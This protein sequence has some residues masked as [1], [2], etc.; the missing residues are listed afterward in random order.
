MQD[1]VNIRGSSGYSRGVGSRVLILIDGLPY[2]TGDTGEIPWKTVPMFQIDRIEVVKG[3]GSALDGS[4]A[5]GGVINVITKEMGETPEIRFR[6]FQGL[7]ARPKYAEWNWSPNARFNSGGFVSYSNR[8]GSFGY[9]VSV[10]RMVDDSYR[11]NDVY[12]RWGLDENSII[13][14]R[15][16]RV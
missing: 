9:L 13:I 1:Q 5:L 14:F 11:E 2:I 12:H 7:Y 15:N 3:A 4:S 16:I 6:L 8:V 10:S